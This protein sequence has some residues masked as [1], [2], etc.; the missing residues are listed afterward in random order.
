M[1]KSEMINIIR[2][3]LDYSVPI[4]ITDNC[5]IAWRILKAIE[6]AGMLPPDIYYKEEGREFSSNEWDSEIPE[7]DPKIFFENDDSE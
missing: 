5:E 1:K 3:E 7:L 6:S 4:E 2:N